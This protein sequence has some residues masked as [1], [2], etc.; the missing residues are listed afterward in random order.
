MTQELG[1]DDAYLEL[2]VEKIDAIIDAIRTDKALDFKMLAVLC[3]RIELSDPKHIRAIKKA[4]SEIIDAPETE[5]FDNRQ[6]GLYVFKKIF[7]AGLET[8]LKE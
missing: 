8:F 6:M 3:Q 1:K 2:D 5:S 7:E 4:F